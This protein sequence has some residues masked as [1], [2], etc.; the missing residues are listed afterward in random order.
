[1]KA[2]LENLR[3]LTKKTYSSPT[4]SVTVIEMEQGIAAG[5]AQTSVTGSDGSTGGNITIEAENGG[6]QNGSFDW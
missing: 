6:E 4:L 1:M 2:D 5:S 3:I